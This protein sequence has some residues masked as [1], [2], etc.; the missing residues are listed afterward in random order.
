MPSSGPGAHVLASG[1]VQAWTNIY[2]L[3]Y[4]SF[5]RASVIKFL[6]KL[7]ESINGLVETLAMDPI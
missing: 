4:L 5:Y 3:G 6:G 1:T 2:S 7:P